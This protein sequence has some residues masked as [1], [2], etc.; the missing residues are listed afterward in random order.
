MWRISMILLKKNF[1]SL[2][3]MMTLSLVGSR[4]SFAA[5]LPKEL[6]GKVT[7][8]KK[9]QRTPTK[10][11]L[12]TRGTLVQILKAYEKRV[13]VAKGLAEKARRDATAK[14]GAADA[15]AQ[16]RLEAERSK[17]AACLADQIRRETIYE[18][19]IK[20]IGA[21]P[22]WYRSPFFVAA[23]AAIVGGGLCVGTVAASR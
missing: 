15:A 6:E 16:I 14:V 18:D 8:M 9:G 21:A 12:L 19:A 1:A 22:P 3:L 5:E 20:R 17:T 7:P 23:T 4:R 10:G 11:L 13:R 2:L